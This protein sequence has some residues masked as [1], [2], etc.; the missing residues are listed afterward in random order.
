MV[1]RRY[2]PILIV[3]FFGSFTLF[4]WFINNETV[5]AF[6]NDDATQWYDIIASFAIF[7]GALNLLKLQLGFSYFYCIY[8]NIFNNTSSI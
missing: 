2:I 4:G 8:A 3:G 6:I 1:L 5:E 7:L